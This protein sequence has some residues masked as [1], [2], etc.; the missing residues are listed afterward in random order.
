MGC[1]SSISQGTTSSVSRDPTVKHYPRQQSVARAE[2]DNFL[3]VFKPGPQGPEARRHRRP[4]R[5]ALPSALLRSRRRPLAWRARVQRMPPGDN[6]T[7]HQRTTPRETV[8]VAGYPGQWAHADCR[9]TVGLGLRIAPLAI[10]RNCGPARHASRAPPASQASEQARPLTR[11]DPNLTA[12]AIGATRRT[13]RV[14]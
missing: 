11:T 13:D 2:S 9:L 8:G 14:P 3:Y 12:A 5:Y 10:M 4:G 1:L 6:E 7:R